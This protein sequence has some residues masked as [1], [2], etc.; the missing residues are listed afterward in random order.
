MCVFDKSK[1]TFPL[2]YFVGSFIGKYDILEF[3]V[4]GTSIALCDMH[5]RYVNLF[6]VLIACAIFTS[7]GADGYISSQNVKVSR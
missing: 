6:V 1:T 3:P 7:I 5:K 2:N 4:V